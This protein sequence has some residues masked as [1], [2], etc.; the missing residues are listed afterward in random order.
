MTSSRRCHRPCYFLFVVVFVVFIENI[1]FLEE[2]TEERLRTLSITENLNQQRVRVHPLID[3]FFNRNLHFNYASYFVNN[4]RHGFINANTRLL[5]DMSGARHRPI[6]CSAEENARSAREI[7]ESAFVTSALQANAEKNRNLV[8]SLRTN[9][10]GAGLEKDKVEVTLA[11]F[12]PSATIAE[13]EVRNKNSHIVKAKG[14]SSYSAFRAFCNDHREEKKAWQM[15]LTAEVLAANIKANDDLLSDLARDSYLANLRQWVNIHEKSSDSLDAAVEAAHGEVTDPGD[16]QTLITISQ[17]VMKNA[18]LR[19]ASEEQL[20]TKSLSEYAEGDNMFPPRVFPKQTGAKF[21]K[22]VSSNKAL[23]LDLQRPESCDIPLA[24]HCGHCPAMA[25]RVKPAKQPRKSRSKKRKKQPRDRD[26]DQSTDDGR[27]IDDEDDDDNDDDDN[28]DDDND[29]GRSCFSSRAGDNQD[30]HPERK[31]VLFLTPALGRFNVLKATPIDSLEDFLRHNA[32]VHRIGDP[33]LVA[34]TGAH[35][36]CILCRFCNE[37]TLKDSFQCC[38]G[39]FGTVI[40]GGKI[41]KGAHRR[42]VVPA[43]AR[44][45]LY[46]LIIRFFSFFQPEH[47]ED[48]LLIKHSSVLVLCRLLKSLRQAHRA[49]TWLLKKINQYLRVQ[50]VL[51]G[52]LYKSLEDR[53]RHQSVCLI[54]FLSLSYYYGQSMTTLEPLQNRYTADRLRQMEEEH[55]HLQMA[56]LGDK[57]MEGRMFTSHKVGDLSTAFD[58][59][60]RSSVGDRQGEEGEGTS[61]SSQEVLSSFQRVL[62][63][64]INLDLVI[65]HQRVKDKSPARSS[66]NLL[67]QYDDDSDEA[68]ASNKD[69]EEPA[70]KRQ[71]INSPVA[72]PLPDV[73]IQPAVVEENSQA[74]LPKT[75][76]NNN[77]GPTRED[78]QTAAAGK[79]KKGAKTSAGGSG[80]V[81]SATTGEGSPK[82]KRRTNQE[83]PTLIRYLKEGKE[84]PEVSVVKTRRDAPPTNPERVMF[85]S[86]QTK[87]L[88]PFQRDAPLIESKK[89]SPKRKKGPNGAQCYKKAVELISLQMSQLQQLQATWLPPSDDEDDNGESGN[90]EDAVAVISSDS[91]VDIEEEEEEEEDEDR[92]GGSG[93]NAR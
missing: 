75:N 60:D 93:K 86:P 89:K 81:R 18:T 76:N 53:D 56:T 70:Y 79:E 47:Y 21:L 13:Y 49:D 10:I 48:H 32:Q 52:A 31:K 1:R 37:T 26:G 36:F 54:R 42:P 55:A 68:A 23:D 58:E 65:Q 22:I 29:D 12:D 82:K 30:E 62:R 39:E 67:V 87:R 51:C 88:H 85:P 43:G 50:C 73:E 77:W 63:E 71:R 44:G 33:N 4:V 35:P 92:S 66:D 61:R 24:F 15:P 40:S 80:S 20:V 5:N 45:T 11:T 91:N 84:R 72:S 7:V 74:L 90:D 59:D 34:K 9:M 28:N 64:E 17:N 83:S 2:E 8:E 46:I 6:L 78:F 38:L 27:G 19:L 25:T 14:F 16:V 3:R 57:V 69:E 41:Q